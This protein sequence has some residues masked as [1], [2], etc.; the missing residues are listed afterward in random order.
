MSA[1]SFI[2][3]ELPPPHPP[4][5]AALRAL[6]AQSGDVVALA[7]DAAAAPRGE[8]DEVPHVDL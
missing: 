6:V 1:E 5:L 7:I 8:G 4:A 2:L 3:A